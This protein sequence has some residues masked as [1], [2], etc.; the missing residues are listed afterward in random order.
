[1]K[2]PN[3]IS[4]AAVAI[5]CAAF[6]ASSAYSQS[7][8]EQIS[9]A[10][11]FGAGTVVA[12]QEKCSLTLVDRLTRTQAEQIRKAYVRDHRFVEGYRY[13]LQAVDMSKYIYGDLV[14][15]ALVSVVNAD[16][17]EKGFPPL[18]AELD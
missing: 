18:F 17:V 3:L 12:Y 1:M 8:A 7:Y 9:E 2:L 13:G 10:M 15:H 14:C 11:I 16:R 4:F 6:A 5:W